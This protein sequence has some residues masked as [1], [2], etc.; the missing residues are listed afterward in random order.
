[1]EKLTANDWLP[2]NHVNANDLTPN[3][4][5]IDAQ[6]FATNLYR[7]KVIEKDNS[8]FY[9]PIQQ[10]ML[11]KKNEQF[12]IYPNPARDRLFIGG[13]FSGY[14]TIKLFDATGKPIWQKSQFTTSNYLAIDLP[15]LTAGI[16]FLKLNTEFKKLVIR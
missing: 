15:I 10:I 6:P 4:T 16:Y 5:C 14:A 12:A 7:L 9:S 8:F 11:N 3:Y 13:D 2:I 1:V